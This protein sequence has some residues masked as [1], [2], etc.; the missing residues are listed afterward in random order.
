MAHSTVREGCCSK[1]WHTESVRQ[2]SSTSPVFVT[3][4]FADY[5]PV[6]QVA[7]PQGIFRKTT[8]YFKKCFEI[9]DDI[10]NQRLKTRGTA[11]DS[12][13]E[14]DMLQALLD[15][16]QKDE[17]ELSFDDIKHLLLVSI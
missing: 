7:D 17:P 15:L 3:P 1:P 2:N 4:N 10:I 5:F 9:F 6:F 12:M 16:N 14:N 13:S 11:E 8:F